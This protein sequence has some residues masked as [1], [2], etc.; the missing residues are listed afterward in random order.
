MCQT[1]VYF[2]FR[3]LKIQQNAFMLSLLT[4]SL[5]KLGFY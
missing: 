2:T 3:V 4:P 5:F 1:E